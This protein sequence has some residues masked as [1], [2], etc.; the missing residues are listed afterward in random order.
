VKRA[1]YAPFF[2]SE[3]RGKR[4]EERGKR[5]EERGKRKGSY[6]EFF[7]SNYKFIPKVKIADCYVQRS[8]DSL[9]SFLCP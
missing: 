6:N 7:E 3:E 5:K 4:K 2:I 9:S 1:L 8:P